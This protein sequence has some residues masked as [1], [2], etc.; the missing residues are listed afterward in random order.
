MTA[1]KPFTTIAALIFLI[2]AVAHAYRLATGFE[3]KIGS[4]AV[5]MSVSWI[6]IAIGALFGAM[7]LVEARR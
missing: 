5:P 2:I 6:G 3:V 7:L 4:T 1:R